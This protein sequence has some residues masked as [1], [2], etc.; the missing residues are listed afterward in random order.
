MLVVDVSV[1]EGLNGEWVL[2]NV[3]VGVGQVRYYKTVSVIFVHQNAVRGDDDLVRV[4][5]LTVGCVT[6]FLYC[7]RGEVA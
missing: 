4:Y 5:D 7:V 6:D 1:V 2:G 3:G